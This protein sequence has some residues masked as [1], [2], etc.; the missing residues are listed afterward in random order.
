[1]VTEPILVIAFNRPDHLKVLIDRLR[2]VQPTRIYFAV[3]GPR[4]GNAAEKHKV[5]ECQEMVSDINWDCEIR[6]HF[7]E[8]NLGCGLGVSTAI[9]WF[10]KHVER[11]MI[12]EDDI[13]P[14]LS[15]FPFCEELLVR[16][17][18]DSQVFAISGCNFVPP[19]EISTHAAYRFS[20]VPHIWGWATWR[21][22]WQQYNLD[23]SGWRED[24]PPTKLWVKSGRSIPAAVYWAG[25]FELLARKEVDTWDGQLVYMCMK[26]GLLTATSNT[27]LIDNIGFNDQA[28]HTLVDLG[29]LQPVTPIS[30]PT[31][32]Q[33]VQLDKKADAWTRKNHF[34]ATW[35]GM[36]DQGDRFLKRRRATRKAKD[37]T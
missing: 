18:N 14:D 3:D 23:I 30:L 34:R 21:N 8:T 7:Q 16:H 25:T 20:Q 32:P 27:N 29:E 15:F 19:E 22:R 36:L 17:E 37:T 24:L 13:I 9:T 4:E 11:G 12:L 28:T 5:T 26:S 6:T 33:L 2:E 10:F 35:R 1:M 31:I